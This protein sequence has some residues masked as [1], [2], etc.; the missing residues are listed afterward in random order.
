[1]QAVQQII[2]ENK[3][4]TTEDFN[5]YF[6]KNNIHLQAVEDDNYSVITYKDSNYTDFSRQFNYCFVNNNGKI[7]HYF[8]P[9][10]Y[11][12]VKTHDIFTGEE[13]CCDLIDK[14]FTY[15]VILYNE[16][17]LIK[18][19]FDNGKWNYSTSRKIDA[20]R[21]FWSSNEKS[22]KELFFE[23]FD[24]EKFQF[25]TDY[26][27]TFL[28]Q[29]PDNFISLPT[30]KNVI[31]A[32]KINMKTYRVYRD[33]LDNFR[34][35]DKTLQGILSNT[36]R[37]VCDNY[38]IYG[39]N[40]N[41]GCE[42]RIKLVSDSYKERQKMLKNS[43]SPIKACIKCL[44]DNNVEKMKAV[45]PDFT[46]LIDNVDDTINE[47]CKTILAIY[48]LKYIAKHKINVDK[49]F[50]KIIHMCHSNYIESKTPITYN[51]IKG[52]IFELKVS[53]I[54]AIIT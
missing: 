10:H 52:F 48:G 6:I 33:E 54:M 28:L 14:S 9:K 44:K 36:D 15:D 53:E 45:L 18:V 32:N 22:F 2:N 39:E 29:H 7:V 35:K 51:D 42:F 19:F 17:S 41:T 16:G 43:Q 4:K 20:S 21:V 50:Q 11:D 47:S 3:L 31:L 25:D 5:N 46:L 37:N 23:I 49:K 40:I 8:E 12:N 38:M 1:M 26:C 24:S 13:N 34:F 30:E 27:Y